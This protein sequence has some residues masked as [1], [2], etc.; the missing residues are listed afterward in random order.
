MDV[1]EDEEGSQSVKRIPD[2]GIEVNFDGLE[3]EDKEVR[4]TYH[5]R[6]VVTGTRVQDGSAEALAEIDSQISKVN[7]EIEHLAPNMKAMDRYG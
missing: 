1:D 6:G 2:Y 4:V 3:N 5:P 7:S